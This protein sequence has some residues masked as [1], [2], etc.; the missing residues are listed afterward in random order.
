M[1]FIATAKNVKRG[2]MKKFIVLLV[3]LFNVIVNSCFAT[4]WVQVDDKNYIDKDSIKYHVDNHG[5][6]NYRKKELWIKVVGDE[7]YKELEKVIN[8][9]VEYGLS[10]YI[11][12][13]ANNT[14]AAKVGMTYDKDGNPVSKFSYSDLQLE[15]NSIAPDSNADLWAKLVRNP[16]M[17]NKIYKM[18]QKDN[19]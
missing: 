10:Q 3:V 1:L 16:R 12:D 19:N 6:T 4:S 8:C 15:Y 11:I 7:Y 2:N 14:I 5:N 9:K 13:Y 17:L 18:Q